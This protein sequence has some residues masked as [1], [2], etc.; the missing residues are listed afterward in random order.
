MTD[1]QKQILETL[2]E[3]NDELQI[4]HWKFDSLQA[5]EEATHYDMTHEQ[6]CLPLDGEN[7]S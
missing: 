4:L 7:C 3:I 6:L 1:I 2:Q 5:V